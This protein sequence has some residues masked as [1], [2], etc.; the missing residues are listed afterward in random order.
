MTGLTKKAAISFG[1]LSFAPF[2]AQ[3]LVGLGGRLTPPFNLVVSNVPGPLEPQYLAGAPLEM[4][5][6]LGL[7]SHGQGLFIAAFTIAGKMGLGFVGDRDSLPHLQRLA[8]YTGEAVD[9]LEKVL[10]LTAPTPA[11]RRTGKSR[12]KQ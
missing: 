4:M 1:A 8:V 11:R 6:P 3:G 10:A 12:P 5:A 9:E 2:V 7:L